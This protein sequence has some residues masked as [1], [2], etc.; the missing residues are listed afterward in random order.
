MNNTIIFPRH[1]LGRVRHSRFVR[2]VVLVASGTAG[3]QAISLAFAPVITRI[4]GPEAF[5]LLGTFTA[6]VSVAAPAA[7]LAFPIAIVLPKDDR[8]ALGLV[9]LSL[10]LSLAVALLATILLALGGDW[11]GAVLGVHS[12]AGFL[13]LVPVAML[14]SAW[15]QI[16]QQWMIRKSEFEIIARSAVEHSLILNSSKA[17]LGWLFPVGPVLIVLATLGHALHAVLLYIGARRR[18]LL[19]PLDSSGSPN[20][21]KLS[22]CELA[23]R[24]RDF[25]YFRAPQNL[26][27][28]A[29]QSLPVLMLAAFFGP[30][31]AGF[32]S[33]GLMVMGAPSGLLGKAV[34]DVFYPRITEA[35]RN[36]E[37]VAQQLLWATG[38][39]FAISL[40]PFGCVFLFGPMLFSLVFGAE[41]F[42]AGEYARWLALFFLFNF[43]NKPSVASVPVLGIQRGLLIYEIF[44]T[45]GKVLALF[46]GFYWFGSDIWAVA[47]F[48]LSGVVT[49]I[50]MM[51][52][53][54]TYAKRWSGNEKAS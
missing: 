23:H 53:I 36:G 24:Y 42:V 35:A 41:W 14:F 16:A 2:N 27:N 20:T 39:M 32:Y 4:Y 10:V 21:H 33:L 9:R 18:W 38:A 17:G 50:A 7:A 47:L 54:L 8:D 11:L 3:A 19:E 37:N 15:L 1:V 45:G 48:S 43:V 22:L 49:Y 44:S 5:G 52:W 51:L 30:A 34:N 40:I 29:S 31:A 13:L 25:P 6:L 26:I 46:A 12:I 28:A